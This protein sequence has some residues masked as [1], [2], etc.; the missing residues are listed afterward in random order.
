MTGRSL[1]QDPA[2]VAASW[3]RHH[4]EAH[5]ITVSVN[6]GYGL[7]VVSVWADLF[8]WTDG[9]WFWWR[10]DWNPRRRRC[11]VVWHPA[12]DPERAARRI[13]F[14]LAQ[15]RRTPSACA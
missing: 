10:T 11:R 8:V 12:N 2:L 3:L 15:L 6:D 13:A 5:G 9:V 7:A 4:L 1:P 14:R